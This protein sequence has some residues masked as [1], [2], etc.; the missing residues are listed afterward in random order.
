MPNCRLFESSVKTLHS[1]ASACLLLS[2]LSL[3]CSQRHD[4]ANKARLKKMKIIHF[5]RAGVKPIAVKLTDSAAA[6]RHSPKYI[7]LLKYVFYIT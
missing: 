6:P 3:L 1:P 5:L 4:Y 2:S 7:L